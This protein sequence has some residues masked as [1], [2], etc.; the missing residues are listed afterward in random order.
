M[1]EQTDTTQLRQELAERQTAPEAVPAND[2]VKRNRDL[3]LKLWGS[4]SEAARFVAGWKA[5]MDNH[6]ELWACNPY[7]LVGG[8]AQAAQLQLHF[9]PQGYIYLLPFKVKG[10]M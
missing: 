7:S 6:P 8:M 4:E 10:H 5:Y 1:T 3:F 2:L 9:G